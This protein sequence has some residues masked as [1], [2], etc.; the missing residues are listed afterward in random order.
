MGKT[1]TFKGPNGQ[2]I[3][4]NGPDDATPEQAWQL[5]QTKMEAPVDTRTQKTK[6]FLKGT[7][8]TAEAANPKTAIARGLLKAGA[9]VVQGGLDLAGSVTGHPEWGDAFT[10]FVNDVMPQAETPRQKAGELI[11]EAAPM[12]A[13]APESLPGM[14]AAGGLSGASQ[15]QE[16]PRSDDRLVGR[17][18]AALEGASLTGLMGAVGK[19]VTKIANSRQ[20]Q[21]LLDTARQ[22]YSDADPAIAAQRGTLNQLVDRLHTR[23]TGMGKQVV[24]EG[25]KL[26]P[27]NMSDVEQKLRDIAEST[28]KMLAPD[29]KAVT[30]LDNATDILAPE[31][32]LPD[33]LVVGGQ[34]FFRDPTGQYLT[35][36]KVNALPQKIVDAALAGKGVQPAPDIRFGQMQQS[37]EEMT[38]YLKRADP[39]N[40]ATKAVK[41]ARDL[42]SSKLDSFKTPTVKTLERKAQSFYEKNLAKYDDPIV[43]DILEEQDPLNRA[44]LAIKVAL[45]DNPKKS[46]VV[47]GLV[48]PKGQQAIREGVMSKGLA[49]AADKDGNINAAKFVKFFDDA[50][51]FEPFQ[52]AQTKLN[53]G[54]IQNLLKEDALLHPTDA[55][56]SL[57]HPSG[58]LGWLYAGI[59]L[60]HGDIKGAGA[61]ASAAF[62]V[63]P[64]VNFVNKMMAD[65][66]G[67]NLLAAASKAVPGSPRAARILEAAVRRFGP[68][69]AGAAS[70]QTTNAQ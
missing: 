34:K 61:S 69:A 25:N 60:M 20:I 12:A 15:F 47:A 44:N 23:Y 2:Q 16:S 52:D 1:F 39:N 17:G 51:G 14:I 10:K 50:K 66:F 4:V 45:G 38:N 31:R 59:R 67:Q 24:E 53:I 58:N 5:A 41:D 49:A 30:I 3:I 64:T 29:K 26:G 62:L 22:A 9:G 70:G 37:I 65:E 21:S 18:I 55:S 40:P 63:R 68:G 13:F 56:P 42:L 43:K 28:G 48:G 54:G 7:L 46:E 8:D 35:K 57:G 19:G 36:D 33:N 27:I 6:E 32:N 11:G